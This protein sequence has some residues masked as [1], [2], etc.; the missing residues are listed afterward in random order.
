MLQSAFSAKKPLIVRRS[1]R[2]FRYWSQRILWGL[3]TIR[4]ILLYKNCS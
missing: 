1:C 4:T 2:T 3:F